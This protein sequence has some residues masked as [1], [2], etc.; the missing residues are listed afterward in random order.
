MTSKPSWNLS[1]EAIAAYER[2]VAST[3]AEP[4]DLPEQVL[5][6]LRHWGLVTRQAGQW[7]AQ[8]A[9][10][11][12]RRLARSLEDGASQVRDIGEG[13]AEVWRRHTGDADVELLTGDECTSML[14][15]MLTTVQ[16]TLLATA[17]PSRNEGV[18]EHAPPAQSAAQARGVQIRAIY[19]SEVL[20]E[21]NG[22]EL[23]QAC[24]AWGE[25]A[26]LLPRV[27]F[28]FFVADGS[29]AAVVPPYEVYAAR[30][31]F[32][33]R[34]P[35]MIAVLTT[36]FEN[37]WTR[38][39]P[40]AVD[41]DRAGDEQSDQQLLVLLANGLSDRAVARELGIS[42]RTLSRRITA[43]SQRLGAQSRFQL[44]FQAARF[45]TTR[46]EAVS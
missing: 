31:M 16:H 19:S 18:P 23:V 42:D 28:L 1:V 8:P 5:N 7:V 34:S 41:Q 44:G 29:V 45:L 4:T 38:S 21:P 22:L 13:L 10:D 6:E 37:L 26:R 25:E 2:I 40:V 14:E 9:E 43:L 32:V 27:P 39:L 15:T 30:Q 36:L 33:F 3:G 20:A 35:G 17:I 12:T 24:V 11:V 46:G